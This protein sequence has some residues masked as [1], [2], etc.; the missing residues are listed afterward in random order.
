MN[1][2]EQMP[3]PPSPLP[4]VIAIASLTCFVSL[5]LFYG[6]A[7]GVISALRVWWAEG[8]IYATLPVFLTFFI[9]YR[10]CWRPEITGVKRTYSLLLLSCAIL[11]SDV[12]AAG[13]MFCLCLLFICVIA[14][15][16][17]AFT[18]GNH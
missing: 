17:N 15:G 14:F 11:L 16:V 18:G 8:L 4:R 9:L 5:I 1:E 6:A 3:E 12:I 13:I 10:S 2:D 7:S